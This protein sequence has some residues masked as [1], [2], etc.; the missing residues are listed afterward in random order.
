MLLPH[1]KT[2]AG[3]PPVLLIPGANGHRRWMSF[4]A[5]AFAARHRT[6]AVTL[7][8]ESE[9]PGLGPDPR[10]APFS[11]VIAR[12]T[13]VLDACDAPR[14]VLCGTSFG[15]VMALS[16]A[17]AHPDRV[18]ALVL[19]AS[20]ARPAR[21]IRRYGRFA[22]RPLLATLVFNAIFLP[23]LPAEFRASLPERRQRRRFYRDLLAL[24]RTI[25]YCPAAFGRRLG[26]LADVD[27]T[28]EL[29]RLNQ[30]VLALS[31]EAGLDAIVDPSEG[32]WIATH[33][34]RGRHEVLPGT[35]HL[36]ILAR[37]ELIVARTERFLDDWGLGSDQDG[38]FSS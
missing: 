36:A 9:A 23:G 27:L 17:L 18:S 30:P 16:L 6:I 32:E 24:R 37:P 38:A 26:R 12:L 25:P 19:H 21:R 10:D 7:P 14:A 20:T 8:G 13:E 3:E 33:T 29:S 11:E 34:D 2:G 4:L 31:G 22:R 28:A 5:R 35:G 1:D 15:G